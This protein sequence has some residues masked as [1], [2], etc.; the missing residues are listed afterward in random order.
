MIPTLALKS[1]VR[2]ITERYASECADVKTSVKSPQVTR[3]RACAG[4]ETTSRPGLACSSN[5]VPTWAVYML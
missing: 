3:D 4:V 2:A 5:R 1:V